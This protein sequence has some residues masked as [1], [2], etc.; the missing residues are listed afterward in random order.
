LVFLNGGHPP[1]PR[2]HGHLLSPI[3]RFPQNSEQRAYRQQFVHRGLEIMRL[4][5]FTGDEIKRLAA[6]LTE[7]GP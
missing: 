3:G 4:Q 5:F 7:Q 1:N 2:H 6:R